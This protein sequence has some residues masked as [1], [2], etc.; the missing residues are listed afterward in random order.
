MNFILAWDSSISTVNDERFDLIGGDLQLLLEQIERQLF[1]RLGQWH[2]A[3][4]AH[5]VDVL[6]VIHAELSDEALVR[7]VELQVL[8][9]FARHEYG[10]EVVNELA[11]QVLDGLQEQQAIEH[12]YIRVVDTIDNASIWILKRLIRIRD[13]LLSIYVYRG[14]LWA[15]SLDFEAVSLV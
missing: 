1:A 4:N 11:F 9:E 5:L 10:E 12:E 6:L 15:S 7:V 14:Y 3:Q 8:M 13:M 2:Q